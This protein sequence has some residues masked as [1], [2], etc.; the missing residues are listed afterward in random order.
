MLD[1][2]LLELGSGG[3]VKL[4]PRA[5]VA[6]IDLVH[7]A[8]QLQRLPLADI[9]IQRTA[10]VVG[11]VVLSVGK[12]PR[13]AEAA[14]DGAALAADAGLDFLPIDGA[15]AAVQGVRTSPTNQHLDF[16]R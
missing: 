4:R 3:G 2:G 10:E 5:A 8:H 9:L 11:N 15:A 12:G 7:I 14:H 1:A 13:A 6:H 16:G